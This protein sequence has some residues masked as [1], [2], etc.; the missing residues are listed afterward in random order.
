MPLHG[1][2]GREIVLFG[3]VFDRSDRSDPSDRSNSTCRLACVK[4]THELRP[5]RSDAPTAPTAPSMDSDEFRTTTGLARARTRIEVLEW[6]NDLDAFERDVHDL[7]RRVA[8]LETPLGVPNDHSQQMRGAHQVRPGHHKV[9]GLHRSRN[10]PDNVGVWGWEWTVRA[11]W[12]QEGLTWDETKSGH[13]GM[14]VSDRIRE[15]L[16]GDPSLAWT[17]PGQLASTFTPINLD[18]VPPG[19]SI[20]ASDIAGTLNKM[21]ISMRKHD[22]DGLLAGSRVECTT[23]KQHY[24]QTGQAA[25]PPRLCCAAIHPADPLVFFP[26]LIR[27]FNASGGF[28]AGCRK[29]LTLGARGAV[30]THKMVRDGAADQADYTA[31][32]KCMGLQRAR[33]EYFHTDGNCVAVLCPPCNCAANANRIRGW[34][35]ERDPLLSNSNE[36]LTAPS[37]VGGPFINIPTPATADERRKHYLLVRRVGQQRRRDRVAA[38]SAT[39]GR[40]R[41]RGRGRGAQSGGRGLGRG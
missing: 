14:C 27:L 24:K 30:V 26:Q 41:G 16:R 37:S 18:T 1:V 33:N 6:H 8:V 10:R 22:Q 12:M 3:R 34:D 20:A 21:L 39:G 28:C 9:A 4:S 40:G 19:L 11:A 23:C 15:L 13:A 7:L 36:D 32:S 2:P 31:I 17:P 29:E 25:P 35:P 38:S 5:R